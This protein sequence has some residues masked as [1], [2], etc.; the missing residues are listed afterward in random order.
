MPHGEQAMSDQR[1]LFQ[2]ARQAEIDRLREAIRLLELALVEC[3]GYLSEVE[4]DVR[5]AGK[6]S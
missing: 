3:R 4:N 6:L 5:G 1:L 2:R